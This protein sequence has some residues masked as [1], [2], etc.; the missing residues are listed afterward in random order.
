MIGQ[1]FCPTIRPSSS[2]RHN[3]FH[4]PDAG[5]KDLEELPAEGPPGIDPE[6]DRHAVPAG[7]GPKDSHLPRPEPC[8]LPRRIHRLSPPPHMHKEWR[9]PVAPGDQVHSIRVPH[10]P[11]DTVSLPLQEAGGHA[12]D[13]P[14]PLVVAVVVLPGTE[15]GRSSQP[16]T[17]RHPAPSPEG[18]CQDVRQ[19]RDVPCTAGPGMRHRQEASRHIRSTSP[20]SAGQGTDT[21][22]FYRPSGDLPEEKVFCLPK[23][24]TYGFPL[25]SGFC[26]HEHTGGAPQAAH[27]AASLFSWSSSK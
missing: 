1:I 11:Y 25:C 21:V 19:R 2:S 27:G 9:T 12:L 5:R 14:P 6:L 16:P 3:T 18:Q 24:G 26:G 7:D 23:K 13:C 8:N 15:A 22:S 10:R 20:A 4:L 17:R